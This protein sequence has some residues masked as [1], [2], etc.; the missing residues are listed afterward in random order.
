MSI[1]VTIVV[2]MFLFFNTERVQRFLN[3]LEFITRQ[4]NLAIFVSKRDR[5]I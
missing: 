1:L 2:I 3:L 4:R 5:S